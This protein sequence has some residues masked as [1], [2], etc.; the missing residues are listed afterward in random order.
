MNQL[1]WK[2]IDIIDEIFTSQVVNVSETYYETIYYYRQDIWP[3]I[4][5]ETLE[6]YILK[7]IYNLYNPRKGFQIHFLSSVTL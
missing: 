6:F 3:K 5:M 2:I 1:Y 7:D 4:G